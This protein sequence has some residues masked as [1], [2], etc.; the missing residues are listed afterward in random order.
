ME[1]KLNKI[2]EIL[3][4]YQALGYFDNDS[5]QSAIEQMKNDS[6]T[7]FTTTIQT[8][9]KDPKHDIELNELLN[10]VWQNL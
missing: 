10:Q 6:N 9:S 4:R 1:I 7:G 2:A 8:K 3:E 5:L